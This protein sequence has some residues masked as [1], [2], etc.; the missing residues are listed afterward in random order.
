MLGLWIAVRELKNIARRL[1]RACR[2]AAGMPRSPAPPVLRAGDSAAGGGFP[3]RAARRFRI[4]SSR[5]FHSSGTAAVAERGCPAR[6]SDPGTDA[7]RTAT[8]T[9]PSRN[10]KAQSAVFLDIAKE[11]ERAQGAVHRSR[12]VRTFRSKP[13][14]AD[15]E[16]D[17]TARAPFDDAWP[18]AERARPGEIPPAAQRPHAPDARRSQWRT[19]RSRDSR[20]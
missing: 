6:S 14:P 19:P 1:G 11:R 7:P 3:C 18:R 17:R 13:P 9:A 15:P 16:P 4:F 20:R 12:C 5:A 10:R 8:A 2:G